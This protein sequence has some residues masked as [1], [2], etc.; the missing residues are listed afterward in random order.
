MDSLD[1]LC[2]AVNCLSVG[3]NVRALHP[4]GQRKDAGAALSCLSRSTCFIVFEMMRG[5]AYVTRV[6]NPTQSGDL[7][8]GRTERRLSLDG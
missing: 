4:S 6:L 8:L 5:I 2:L 1:G 7:S 3:L